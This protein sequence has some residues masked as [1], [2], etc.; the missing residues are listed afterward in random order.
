MEI[1]SFLGL[2]AAIMSAARRDCRLICIDPCDLSGDEESL[3]SYRALGLEGASQ[4]RRLRMNLALYGA[5]ARVIR[6]TSQ[7]ALQSVSTKFHLLFVDGDHSYDVCAHDVNGYAPYLHEGGTL[8]LHDATE[9]GWPGPIKVAHELQEC[10]D[11]ELLEKER[12]L[13]GL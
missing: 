8:I 6:A 11:W 3:V 10:D 9:I 5:R 2:S 1:G 12:Q 4:Y 13:C 7:K